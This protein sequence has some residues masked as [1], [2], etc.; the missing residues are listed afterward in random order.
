[1]LLY[2][3]KTKVLY[4]IPRKKIQKWYLELDLNKNI[5]FYMN[6]NILIVYN[7][8]TNAKIFVKYIKWYL[9]NVIISYKQ[10]NVIKLIF[11]FYLII[12]I[13]LTFV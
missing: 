6:L 11:K 3:Y 10:G 9:V 1:M 4:Q 5:I 13:Y 2:Y 7:L 12:F 8:N